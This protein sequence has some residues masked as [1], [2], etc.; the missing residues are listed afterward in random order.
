MKRVANNQSITS[1]SKHHKLGGKVVIKEM[2]PESDLPFTFQFN[3][4][5]GV[6]VND[7]FEC[8]VSWREETRVVLE[9]FLHQNGEIVE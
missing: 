5:E 7:T 9:G 3:F 1:I 6:I 8:F 4:E 2:Q